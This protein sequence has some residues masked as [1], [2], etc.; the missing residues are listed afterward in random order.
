MFKIKFTTNEGP[1]Y[2]ILYLTQLDQK[3][4]I[5]LYLKGMEVLK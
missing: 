5:F 2:F 3:N 4:Y 1:D